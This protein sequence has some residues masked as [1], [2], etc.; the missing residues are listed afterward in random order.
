M[1]SYKV[2]DLRDSGVTR[3]NR[4]YNEAVLFHNNTLNYVKLCIIILRPIFVVRLLVTVLS[5]ILYI[6]VLKHLLLTV[7]CV[8]VLRA[9]PVQLVRSTLRS[10]ARG[11][12]QTSSLCL[13][14]LRFKSSKR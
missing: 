5:H 9:V 1:V 6:K 2:I 4:L 8:C 13:I 14:K 3:N 10:V 11:P 12:P 7:L